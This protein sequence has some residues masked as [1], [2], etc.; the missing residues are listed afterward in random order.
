LESLRHGDAHDFSLVDLIDRK[1]RL[2]RA[3]NLGDFRVDE[4]LEIGAES[5]LHATKLLGR[6]AEKLPVML[7]V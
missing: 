3:K 4:K 6:L 7:I 2:V 5:P 1:R